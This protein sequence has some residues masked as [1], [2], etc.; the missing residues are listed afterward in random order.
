M[1]GLDNTGAG[2]KLGNI[3]YH[4]SVAE[5]CPNLVIKFAY[6]KDLGN[7]DPLNISGVD[8]EK[9]SGQ[10][11]GGLYITVLITYKNASVVNG[12]PVTLSLALGEG[13]ERN[14]IF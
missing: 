2:L 10:G 4:Q 12:K 11:R 5:C 3:Y 14:T 9:E 1:F 7:M 8:G 13:V 6:L